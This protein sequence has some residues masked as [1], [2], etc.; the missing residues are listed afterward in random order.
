ME[1][2]SLL[3]LSQWDVVQNWSQLDFGLNQNRHNRQQFTYKQDDLDPV[4][5]CQR[6]LENWIEG[7]TA[8]WRYLLLI[9]NEINLKNAAARIASLLPGKVI[10]VRSQK[11]TI[12]IVITF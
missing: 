11:I 12:V 5:S 9:L 6:V 10:I 7:Q 4:M 2:L 8:S 3:V 1:Q